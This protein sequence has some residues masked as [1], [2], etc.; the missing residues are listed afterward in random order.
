MQ[1]SDE[2]RRGLETIKWLQQTGLMDN[3][4]V[5]W[6]VRRGLR[7][8]DFSELRAYLADHPKLV[9]QAKAKLKIDQMWMRENPFYP[10]PQQSDFSGTIPVGYVN[11]QG[12]LFKLHENDIV[13]HIFVS[14]KTGSGKSNFIKILLASIRHNMNSSFWL[15]DP[16]REYRNLIE[17]LPDTKVLRIRDMWDNPFE[18]P[19]KSIPPLEWLEIISQIFEVELGFKLASRISLYE[20]GKY[21]YEQRGVLE[22][23]DNWP[24]CWDFI[25]VLESRQ[26]A[27]KT[28][29]Q[30]DSF[31]PLLDRMRHLTGIGRYFSTRKSIPIQ[32]LLDTNLIF[33]FESTTDEIYRLVMSL[34]I[35][36]AFH[37]RMWNQRILHKLHVNIVE[38]GRVPFSAKRLGGVDAKEPILNKL[39]AQ[40][41]KFKGSFVLLTQ[42]PS[43]ISS[44]PKSN[45]NT[46]ISL[47]L[48]HG[49]E[50]NDI[51]KAMS[52]NPAQYAF[53]SK[54]PLG[55]GLVKYDCLDPFL[56]DFPNVSDLFHASDDVTID[57]QSRDFLAK[58]KSQRSTPKTKK[59]D[60]KEAPATE[61]NAIL[62]P[63]AM[64][65]LYTLAESP[66][67]KFTE[68]R[69]AV[70]FGA[71]KMKRLQENLEAEGWVKSEFIKVSKAKPAK[72]LSLTGK[73][74]DLI[75]GKPPKGKGSFKSKLYSHLVAQHVESN[76]WKA[77]IE[78]R[79]PGSDKLI[80]VLATK[81]GSHVAYEITNSFGNVLDNIQ[82]DIEAGADRVVILTEDI[83]KLKDIIG[84][85]QMLHGQDRVCV[86]PI[87]D[88][89]GG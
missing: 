65:V 55:T 26:K 10:F 9:R 50:R 89:F 58:F 25:N 34:L 35:T 27:A 47:P 79:I 42:E 83:S 33:E 45:V 19:C 61:T 2:F 63:D 81:K 87:N 37:Y 14:G 24:T 82:Q 78:G 75:P 57:K 38:E 76:G 41:R 64:K 48:M 44:T 71:S 59:P 52:L 12:D 7:N 30:K 88:F 53:F 46:M 72:F 8:G 74:Y 67:V 80:D 69:K 43:A 40:Y 84:T 31:R 85:A 4:F 3:E 23:S 6:R 21:I 73:A 18:P 36:K 29:Y 66:F 11:P 77:Q 62:P 32:A 54:L 70:G 20:T 17:A 56:I 1:K 28:A 86:Q 22:G 68:L 49:E 51:R 16:S 13:R 60:E 15:F 5:A 39:M